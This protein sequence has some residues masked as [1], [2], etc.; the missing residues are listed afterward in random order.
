MATLFGLIAMAAS[1][2]CGS[3][4][5][6]SDIA[7]P[8]SRSRIDQVD[9]HRGRDNLARLPLRRSTSLVFARH[10]RFSVQ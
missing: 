9:D 3:A 5:L 10:S 7:L 8:L 1:S 6:A 4:Q 2:V